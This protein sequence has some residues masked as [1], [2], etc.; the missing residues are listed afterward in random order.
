MSHQFLHANRIIYP[1]FYLSQTS[2][3]LF[4]SFIHC[5]DDDLTGIP[6]HRPRSSPKQQ[7]P[8]SF[9][10]HVAGRCRRFSSAVSSCCCLLVGVSPCFSS[11]LPLVV[12][13]FFLQQMLVAIV[14]CSL[15]PLPVVTQ[16][17]SVCIEKDAGCCAISLHVSRNRCW[18]LAKVSSCL[19]K[20]FLL[21]AS[22]VRRESSWLLP[23]LPRI[24]YRFFYR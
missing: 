24:S 13:G 18:L 3:R 9:I 15:K 1:S 22:H 20:K 12:R 17:S 19:L 7:R 4:S 8:N 14:P 11:E 5:S 16:G 21:V 23:N 2:G 6:K 10:F